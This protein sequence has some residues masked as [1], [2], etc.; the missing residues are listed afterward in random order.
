MKLNCDPYTPEA[1]VLGF[2]LPGTGNFF[3]IDQVSCAPVALDKSPRAGHVNRV[4]TV[5][6]S[7]VLEANARLI[8]GRFAV[9]LY[10]HAMQSCVAAK[11]GKNVVGYDTLEVSIYTVGNVGDALLPILISVWSGQ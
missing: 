4:P 6:K 10:D 11:R 9:T 8:P 2:R 1:V 7:V 5:S 3:G